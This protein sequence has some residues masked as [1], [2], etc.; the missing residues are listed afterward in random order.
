MIFGTS[1]VPPWAPLNAV[2]NVLR[3]ILTYFFM[4]FPNFSKFDVVPNLSDGMIIS[5]GTIFDCFLWLILVRGGVLALTG[6]IIF[7]R[8]ELAAT[9]AAT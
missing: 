6:W 1:M 9:T 7:K 4:L 5:L 2:D 8:R 3:N